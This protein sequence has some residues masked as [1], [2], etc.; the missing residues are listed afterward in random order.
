M[1]TTLTATL[2]PELWNSHDGVRGVYPRSS[3]SLQYQILKINAGI[4]TELGIH[5]EERLLASEFMGKCGVL[6]SQLSTEIEAF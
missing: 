4:N 6:W 5:M 3:K 2:T 1:T